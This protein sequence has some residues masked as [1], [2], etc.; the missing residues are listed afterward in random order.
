VALK[1]FK[2]DYS[3]VGGHEC[4][5]IVKSPRLFCVV[6]SND[7]LKAAFFLCHSRLREFKSKLSFD[8]LLA[9]VTST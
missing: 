4:R 6:T 1:R 3:E 7:G 2:R 8:I 5:E 9:R